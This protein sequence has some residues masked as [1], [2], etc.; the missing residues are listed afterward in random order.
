MSDL[1]EQVAT[2]VQEFTMP[3]ETPY[4]IE[5]KLTTTLAVLQVKPV[6][7]QIYHTGNGHDWLRSTKGPHVFTPN[8]SEVGELSGMAGE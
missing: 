1:Y 4:V 2:P 8:P 3:S 6:G 7:P 5:G